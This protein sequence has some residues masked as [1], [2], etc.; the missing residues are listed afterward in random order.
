MSHMQ[1]AL[2][3]ICFACDLLKEAREGEAG[4][5]RKLGGFFFQAQVLR[6]ALFQNRKETRTHTHT[7]IY[8]YIEVIFSPQPITFL[9][10]FQQ[11]NDNNTTTTTTNN[12]NN[13]KK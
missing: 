10:H 2:T 3:L 1:V 5:P 11:K 9:L 4:I 7:H 6:L 8:I 12:N 13:K